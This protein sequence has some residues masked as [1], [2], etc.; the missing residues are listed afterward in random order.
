MADVNLIAR[1]L[2]M[3][4]QQPIA[5]LGIV[6]GKKHCLGQLAYRRNYTA[7]STEPGGRRNES[8]V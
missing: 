6:Y 1:L 8:Q 2:L 5:A 7:R 3:R 4:S